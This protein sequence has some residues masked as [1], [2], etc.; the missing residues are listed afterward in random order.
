MSY[1]D[2]GLS[3]G[4]DYR[5]AVTGSDKAGNTGSATIAI[6]A[7][8]PLLSPPPGAEVDEPPVLV[9]TPVKR[10]RYYNLQLVRGP[11]ILTFGLGIRTFVSR[12]PW[13]FEGTVTACARAGTGGTSGPGSVNSRAASYGRSLGGSSFV[14]VSKTTKRSSAK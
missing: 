8:G 9:W 14:V 4:K 2:A 7:T 6:T 11:K 1:R 5:Y 12:G 3:V 10:A 13:V